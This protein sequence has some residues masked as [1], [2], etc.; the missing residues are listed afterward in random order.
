MKHIVTKFLKN[1]DKEKNL[2]ISQRKRH[3]RYRRTKNE[4]RFLFRNNASQKTM[5]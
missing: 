5:V 4:N 2:K 1:I 3:M